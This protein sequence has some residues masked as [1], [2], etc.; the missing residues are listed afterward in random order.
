MRVECIKDGDM[1]T[2]GY[3]VISGDECAVI[4][5]ALDGEKF[6][7]AAKACGCNIKYILLTHGHYDHIGGADKLSDIC[8]ADVYI[9]ELDRELLCDP[10]KNASPDYSPT[11]CY[12]MAKTYKDGD[13]FRL[14][15][16]ELTVRHTPGHTKGSCCFF[17]G[18][19]VFTGDTLFAD[20][21]GRTDLYGGDHRAIYKSLMALLR[22]VKGKRI[23][24]GH[25]EERDF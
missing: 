17:C 9:H 4:D 12:S 22:E 16:E 1:P 20:G 13:V 8:G 6:F 18:D 19:V 24:P 23:Y 3:I 14:G 7:N 15:C 25:G 2:N 5:P 10:Q 11:V 21:Y